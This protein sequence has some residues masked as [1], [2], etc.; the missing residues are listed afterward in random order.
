MAHRSE[1]FSSDIAAKAIGVQ[2]EAQLKLDDVQRAAVASS[3][4]PLYLRIED[5]NSMAH[6]VEARLPF[7]DHRVVSY[8]LTLPMQLRINGPWNK[9]ALRAGRQ[10]KNSRGGADASRQNGLSR[11]VG[12]MVRARAIR[13]PTRSAGSRSMRER[14]LYRT[15]HMIRT[16]EASRGA[17]VQDHGP[18]F[19]AANV[20]LWLSMIGSRAPMA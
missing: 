3:P 10:G 15:D 5:R 13:T 9:Y 4:L 2:A 12:A 11:A 19:R 17:E 18:I 6:S 7:L 20:E 8:A 16:L 14:G 1:W